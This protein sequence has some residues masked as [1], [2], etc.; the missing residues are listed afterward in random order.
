MSR[1]ICGAPLS[2][3]F[4]HLREIPFGAPAAHH[5]HQHRN[6]LHVVAE[7]SGRKGKKKE[8]CG[9]AWK[10][11]IHDVRLQATQHGGH[12][13]VE[14]AGRRRHETRRV[15]AAGRTGTTA[16]AMFPLPGAGVVSG[17]PSPP[18][19]PSHPLASPNGSLQDLA[20]ASQEGRQGRRRHLHQPGRVLRHFGGAPSATG[21]GF[22]F[23]GT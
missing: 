19:V 21:R 4:F 6:D 2:R 3:F 15:G 1:S 11:V 18:A 8:L 22:G 14:E 9:W 10:I 20:P 16:M 7:R 5:H 17:F 13:E 23:S 12:E